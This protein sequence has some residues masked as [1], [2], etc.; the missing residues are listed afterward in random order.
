MVYGFMRGQM[1]PL[2][3]EVIDIMTRPTMEA[4]LRAESH[5]HA[6]SLERQGATWRRFGPERERTVQPLLKQSAGVLSQL[7]CCRSLR[8]SDLVLRVRCEN[9]K[10]LEKLNADLG[11]ELFPLRAQ[12]LPSMRRQRAQSGG[13]PVS[14]T[15]GTFLARHPRGTQQLLPKHSWVKRYK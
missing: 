14:L 15:R 7:H 8:H 9:G 3:Q 12:C 6:S 10:L 13:S 11:A 4:P 1:V 2:K 5:K